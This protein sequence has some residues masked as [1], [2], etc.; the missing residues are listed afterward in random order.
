MSKIDVAVP[1]YNYGRY[2]R[3]CIESITSQNVDGLR[4]VIID[5]AST[6]DSLA[7]AREL[8]A[9]DNRIEI[10]AHDSNV[11]P[12]RSYNEAIDWAKSDYFLLVDADDMLASGSLQRAVAI[13][14]A[15]PNVVLC[16]GVEARLM[17][18]GDVC[19]D[20]GGAGDGASWRITC[21]QDFIAQLIRTPA[22]RVGAP[23][24]VRRTAAQKSVGGYRPALPFTDDLEMWL[25][26]AMLGSVAETGSVQ[27]VRRIHASQMTNQYKSA[28]VQ[29]RDFIEREKAFSSFFAHEGR[30]LQSEAAAMRVIR[31]GLA[32]NAY[33]SALSHACR[34]YP[35]TAFELLKFTASRHPGALIIPPVG[36][37]MRMERP[38]GRIADVMKEAVYSATRPLRRA[39]LD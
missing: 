21:G 12:N 35:K 2:L 8:A 15:N 3:D 7:V 13:M 6:D 38:C 18:C 5:N 24:V 32:D 25:R 10:I 29:V 17:P 22:N 11:G 39:H 30:V 27:A 28:E 20:R 34:G 19:V 23:T 36:W 9:Q 31:H 26:L 16:H 1:C 37:L 4:V 14:D 33:W